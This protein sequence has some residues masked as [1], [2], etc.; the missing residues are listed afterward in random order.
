MMLIALFFLLIDGPRLI[1]WLE[2][3]VPLRQGELRGLLSEF[4]TVSRA[5][6][7]SM[8]ISASVQT[9]AA[10]AGYLIARVPSPLFFAGVTFVVALI[11]VI[12]AA[13]VCLVA[14]ILLYFT[15]HPM[16]A[17]FLAL[18]AVGVVALI[19]N[20]VTPYLVSVDV[21]MHGA[22]VFF[23]MVGG[24]LAFGTVGLLVGPLVANLFLTLIS[25]Y[26][27]SYRP[28]LKPMGAAS[29]ASPIR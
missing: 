5:V 9:A 12:G 20:F 26:R 18:W 4:H 7:Q 22:V 21:E 10:L 2:R 1:N 19:D 8:L 14:A 24:I 17:L 16:A 25:M 28:S 23:S 6:L 27:R 15:G 29:D 11:P 3:V 13:S